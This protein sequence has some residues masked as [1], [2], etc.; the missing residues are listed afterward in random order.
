MD[1]YDQIR[2]AFKNFQN[3]IWRRAYWTVSC[4]RVQALSLLVSKVHTSL[5]E[6]NQISPDQI[7]KTKFDAVVQKTEKFPSEFLTTII[8]YCNTVF[9]MTSPPAFVS[10]PGF[11]TR[12]IYFR[13]SYTTL[14]I[15]VRHQSGKTRM[16]KT[17]NSD[18]AKFPST[19]DTRLFPRL[20]KLCSSTSCIA[21]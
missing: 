13:K 19:P 1:K 4:F 6:G 21:T 16:Q 3:N 7:Y 2:K 11:D 18:H 17:E 15:L 9:T 5:L 10:W 8:C 12:L 20:F 14:R